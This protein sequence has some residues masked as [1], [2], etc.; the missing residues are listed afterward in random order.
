MVYSITISDELRSLFS[1]SELSKENENISSWLLVGYQVRK[2]SNFE[3]LKRLEQFTY[4]KC[5]HI[6]KNHHNIY[7]T[8]Q[9]FTGEDV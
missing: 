7:G 4:S 1:S 9:V 5:P 6:A 8:L 2:K 3:Q